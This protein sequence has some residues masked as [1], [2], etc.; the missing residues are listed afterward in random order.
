MSAAAIIILILALLLVIFTLQNTLLI[1]LKIFFWELTDVPL[2]LALIVCLILGF[3]VAFFLYYPSVFKMKKKIKSLEKQLGGFGDDTEFEISEGSQ[4]DLDM[5]DET[6][7]E[8][9]FE[10]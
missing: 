8:G 2:V 4:D 6:K 3:L 10:E 1:S 7:N 9:F 5:D